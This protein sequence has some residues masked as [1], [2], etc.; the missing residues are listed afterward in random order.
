MSR[1]Y[2][3]LRFKMVILFGLIVLIGCFVLFYIS[4]NQARRALKDEASE[5]LQL[6]AKATAETINYLVLSRINVMEGIA[7]HQIIRGRFGDREATL[8]EKLQ[9][10]RD[11]QRRVASQ[12]FKQLG[13]ADMQ[14][15]AIFSD[16]SRANDADRDYFKKALEG[17]TS[18][19]STIVSRLD[20][21]I[22]F[23]YATP[24]RH[25]DTDEITGVLIGVIDATRFSELV[26][27]INYGRTGYGFAVDSNGKIIAHK[28]IEMVM[29][30]ENFIEQAK[31]DPSLAALADIIFKMAKGEKGIGHYTFR[32]EEKL[33]GF[34]PIMAT[35]WSVGIN[36]PEA[37]VMERATSLARTMQFVSLIIILLALTLTFVI[38][39][40]ITK[41]IV[42]LTRII[43]RLAEYDFRFD[44]KDEAVKYLKREDEIGQI[45]NALAGMQMNISSLIKSLKNDAQT[46]ADNSETLSATSEEIASSSGEVASAIQQVASGATNQAGYLQ[47]ILGLI[48]NITAS[49]E[50]VYTELSRVKE[51]SEE[52]S[53]LADTGKQE[54]D[55]LIVSIKGVRDAF[56]TVVER[57]GVLKGSV[58]QVAEILE[59]INGITDQTNLLAL[60][61]AIEAARAGEAGRGFAVVAEEVRKL[62]EQSR[63]SSD[64]IAN[65]LNNITSETNEVVATSEEV[66]EQVISQLE[67]VEKTI[68]AFNEILESVAAIGPMIEATYREVDDTVK[69]KDMVIDKVQSVSSV[70]EETSASAEEISA[71]AEELSASTQEIASNAQ[72]V[73]EVAKRLDKQVGR[74][75]V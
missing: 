46:L 49:L 72:Q 1:I 25:Y 61:A 71:S 43:K 39:T 55:N 14:G 70:A 51:N 13:I 2:G 65:L 10:L 16:G 29:N 58:N 23:V 17:K 60:N 18:V 4:E 5:A 48:Q 47:E 3:S 20:N 42:N 69:A 64:K 75:R 56:K 59:V 12:G 68:K 36:V 34:A 15:N 27:S 52:T 57:L 35:G 31:S 26:S 24:V 73:M 37:E 54:L 74:F 62:A 7:N 33:I 66:S 8:E 67:N 28:D 63:A 50:K 45:T 53:K 6:T 38:A 9:V 21:S 44:E 40:T 41:P 11:E 32:D 30:Q 19:S 22:V